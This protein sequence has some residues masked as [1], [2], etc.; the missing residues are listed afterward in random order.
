MRS[1]I[2]SLEKIV[3]RMR[4][5]LN[6]PF[7]GK[8]SEVYMHLNIPIKNQTKGSFH[9]FYENFETRRTTILDKKIVNKSESCAKI[10]N[11]YPVK[12]ALILAD[13]TNDAEIRIMCQKP[14]YKAPRNDRKCRFC[15]K[16]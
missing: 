4:S 13:K 10:Q 5:A 9:K 14:G 12:K 3:L 15:L 7:R 11:F 1:T 2:F 6:F 16:T 8:F